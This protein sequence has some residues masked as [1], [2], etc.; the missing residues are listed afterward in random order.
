MD[1]DSNGK[2]TAKNKTGKAT[3]TITLKSTLTKTIT[4]KV[5]KT[6]VKTK[7]VKEVPKTLSLTVGKT[8]ELKPVI[9][10]ITSKQKVTYKT[11]NK[12]IATVNSKGVITAKKKGKVT[13]TVKSGSKSAKCKVTIK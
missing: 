8:Y 9:S 13:I 6:A 7:S 12:K 4:V 5:Q 3:I 10:P 1:V 11:S 2:I